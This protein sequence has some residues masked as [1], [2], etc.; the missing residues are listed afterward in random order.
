MN[1][2]DLIGLEIVVI[3]DGR[4]LGQILDATENA[5]GKIVLE[6]SM[7]ATALPAPSPFFSPPASTTVSG[8]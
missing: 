3:D 1:L 2:R 7:R 5:S 8:K 4:N 6:L